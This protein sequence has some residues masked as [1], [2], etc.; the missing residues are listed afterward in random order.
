M[1]IL[2]LRDG[3]EKH[4]GRKDTKLARYGVGGGDIVTPDDITLHYNASGELEI[5]NLGVTNAKIA[6][7]AI[8]TD[9]IS[10]ATTGGKVLKTIDTAGV[11]TV[12]WEDASEVAVDGNS[13]EFNSDDE[14]SAVLKT[15]GGL[16]KSST[17]IYVNCFEYDETTETLTITLPEV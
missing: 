4:N 11:K 7:Q 12:S 14:L 3:I 10:P 5:K 9:K 17:G 13:I 1:R 2:N 6:S 8:T 16:S 15:D